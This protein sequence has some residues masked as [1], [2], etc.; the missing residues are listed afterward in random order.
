MA[1]LF[2]TEVF[3]T[4]AAPRVMSGIIAL[5]IFG[6]IVVMTF[7]ASRGTISDSVF[8]QDL[9]ETNIL[10]SLVKQEIAKEG[11]FGR[12]LSLFFASSTTTPYA[13]L[14]ARLFPSQLATSQ[15]VPPEQS[16][17]A[18]LFLHW[19]FSMIM[20]GATSSTIPNISYT[21]LVSLYSYTVVVLVGF[22]VAGGLLYLRFLS[23]ERKTWKV[24][25]GFRPWGGPAAAII[26]CLVCT[27]LIIAAFLPPSAGS[28]FHKSR[29][30]VEWWIVP[31]VGLGSLALAYVYYLVFAYAVPRM[32]KQRLFVERTATIVRDNGEWVQAVERVEALWIAREVPT[33]NSANGNGNYVEMVNVHAK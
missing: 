23:D 21:I 11:I 5:S 7:T 30:E 19:V 20:I 28:P 10:P 22:F 1:T 3:G 14:K 12:R 9:L 2:F 32:K 13:Y 8:R 25:A 29:T 16:P 31:T 24:N 26:Y 27:F 4:N 18:A 33:A 6:N 17:A 15:Q